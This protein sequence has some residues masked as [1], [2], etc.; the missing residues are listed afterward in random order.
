M[1]RCS[2]NSGVWSSGAGLRSLALILPSAEWCSSMSTLFHFSWQQLYLMKKKPNPFVH[3]V[4]GLT[5]E[6]SPLLPGKPAS[7][8]PA[9]VLSQRKVMQAVFWWG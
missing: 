9:A 2:G 7:P 6:G 4:L 5:R 3:S 8:S 1:A